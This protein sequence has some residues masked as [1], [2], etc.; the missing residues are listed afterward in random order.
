MA[1]YFPA[2]LCKVSQQWW[3]KDVHT[4]CFCVGITSY[5]SFLNVAH[6]GCQMVQMF[7]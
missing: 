6:L 4:H 1:F 5:S 2:Q 3:A 7:G